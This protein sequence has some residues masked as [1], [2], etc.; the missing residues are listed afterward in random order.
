MFG[1]IHTPGNPKSPSENAINEEHVLESFSEMESDRVIRKLKADAGLCLKRIP[2]TRKN[3]AQPAIPMQRYFDF[4]QI[5]EQ[6]ACMDIKDQLEH[7]LAM[8]QFIEAHQLRDKVKVSQEDSKKLNSFIDFIADIRALAPKP[9]PVSTPQIEQPNQK[10]RRQEEKAPAIMNKK[11]RTMPGS[12]VPAP[13]TS[14]SLAAPPAVTRLSPARFPN[15]HEMHNQYNFMQ[16]AATPQVTPIFSYQDAPTCFS[17][18]DRPIWPRYSS[19]LPATP[20][21]RVTPDNTMRNCHPHQM[22]VSTQPTTPFRVVSPAMPASPVLDNH[23]RTPFDYNEIPVQQQPSPWAPFRVPSPAIPAR[24]VVFDNGRTYFDHNV[25]PMQ[26]P[27]PRT[28]F[29]VT[30]PAIS[31]SPAVFDNRRTYFDHNVT[32][33]QQQP[34]PRMQFPITSPA[35]PA[36]PPVLDNNRRTPFDYYEIPVQQ[37]PTT[38]TQFRFPSPAIPASPVVLDNTRTHFNRHEIPAQPIPASRVAPDNTTTLD[39]NAT[40]I[41]PKTRRSRN[42][43]IRYYNYNPQGNSPQGSRFFARENSSP[44]E[45]CYY[46]PRASST[47]TPDSAVGTP[48]DAD[49]SQNNVIK[50]N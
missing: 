46:S 40:P 48:Q 45:S 41:R 3:I 36:S 2:F 20:V 24:P 43:N 50:R 18:H 26:Q 39:E 30:S 1:H 29:P 17:L 16:P 7:C 28:Q 42:D 44:L 37:R 32:P 33:M 8:E 12:Q 22:P 35:I 6:L 15:N 11:A 5:K 9:T 27:T 10:R 25:T 31:A 49:A 14:R 38:T 47:N 23:R 13:L 4:L 19:K 34:S 21:S